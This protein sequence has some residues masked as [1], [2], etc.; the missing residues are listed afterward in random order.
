[1]K[2]REGLRKGTEKEE[3]EEDKDERLK[4]IKMG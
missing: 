2:G 1:M 4:K 3:G